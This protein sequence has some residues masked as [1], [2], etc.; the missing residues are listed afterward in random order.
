MII[1]GPYLRLHRDQVAD[2]ITAAAA[3]I[4]IEQYALAFDHAEELF[5]PPELHDVL[6][7][8]RRG[9]IESASVM[10]RQFKGVAVEE[11]LNPSRNAYHREIGVGR[12][13]MTQSK[14]E[15]PNGPIREATH[16][17][18][19]AR[20]SQLSL[21]QLLEGTPLDSEDGLALWACLV[22]MPA[23]SQ[24]RPAMLRLAFPFEDGTWEESYR[25]TDLIPALAGYAD[26][27]F[28]L[29]MREAAKQARRSA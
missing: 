2:D 21:D 11:V 17:Q 23:D 24:D 29:E 26:S 15:R 14:V 3:R 6:P 18:T 19:L 27:L 13:V 7:S 22:H 4:V 9:A 8:F 1:E 20:R 12:V 28:V 5:L 10:L 25:L 16:R